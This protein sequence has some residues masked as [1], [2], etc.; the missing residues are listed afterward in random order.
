V[1]TVNDI[2]QKLRISPW[3]VRAYIR[4]GNLKAHRIGNRFRVDPRDLA[5]FLA[6]AGEAI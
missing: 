5:A 6:R 3:T 1:L 4:A 2:A